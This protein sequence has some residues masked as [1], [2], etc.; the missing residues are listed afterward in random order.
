M[1]RWILLCLAI[2]MPLVAHAQ[3]DDGTRLERLI[4]NS[5]SDGDAFDVD[6]SGFRGALSSNATLERLTISDR[7]G[8]WL[9]LEDA[10]LVWSRAA[11]LRGRLEVDELS[12]MRLQVMRPPVAQER[13][14]DLPTAEATPFSLPDLPVSIDID[15]IAIA[16]VDLSEPVIGTAARLSV[17]GGARLSDGDGAATLDMRRLDGPQG[18]IDLDARFSNATRDLEI[19]LLVEE[20]SGGLIGEMIDLPGRPSLRL[21]M[22]GV[23]PL[24]D[25]TADISLSTDGEDRLTGQIVSARSSETT[26]QTIGIDLN[27][28]IS[29][30]IQPD[31]RAFFGTQVA[32][33]SDVT[34][35]ADGR[36]TLENLALV[37][38]AL[39]IEGN[40][41]L[42]ENKQPS[43]FALNA[44]MTDPDGGRVRLPIPGSDVTLDQMTLTAGFD[45]AA[46]DSYDAQFDLRGL[47]AADAAVE[48]MAINVAGALTADADGRISA[49][50]ADITAQTDNL[51]HTDPALQQALGAAQTLEAAIGWSDGQ[52]VRLDELRILAGDLALAGDGDL[53][54]GDGR[55]DIGFVLT[56]QADNLSRFEG[57]AGQPLSG[58]LQTSLSGRADLLSGAFE[59]TLDGAAQDLRL[60]ASVPPALFRGTTDLTVAAARDG[61]GVRLDQLNLENSNLTLSGNGALNSTEG[62]LRADVRLADLGLF[63][64][65]VRGHAR[66]GL[67]MQRRDGGPWALE[68]DI[69]GPQGISVAATGDVG[70]PDGAV[71]LS[72]T[73]RLPLALANPALS[74]RSVTG[75]LGFDLS[76]EGQPGLDTL[77]GTFS[78]SGAR[79]SLPTLQTALDNLSVN[80]QLS[81]GRLRSTVSGRLATGGAL[82]ADATVDLN[83]PS[84]PITAT[85]TGRTLRLIDPTLYDARIDRADLRYSGALLGS[86]VLSGSV[87]LGTVEIRVPETGLGASDIPEIRHIGETRAQRQTRVDA[88]LIARGNGGDSRPIG[89]DLTIDAPGQ[90]FI[91]GRGL[92]AEL[93]GSLRLGGTSANV[94]PAGRFDLLRGRLSILGTRLDLTE[95]SATLQGSLDPFL[96]LLATSRAGAYTIGISI[97]GPVTNPD[98]GFSSDPVLPEDEVLAQ[99]LFGRSIS[100][101]SAIQ[102][103]QLADAAASLAGG[104]QNAGLFVALRD[105]LGLD[106]LDLETDEQGN[107]ALRAGRYLSENIYTDLS[108][109]AEGETDLSLNIDLTSDI[110]AR[111]SF[112]SDGDSSL[113][114]FFERDY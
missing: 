82:E 84:L 63:N 21:S 11:L 2:L 52:P 99:L 36:V 37:S 66:A 44:R 112:S 78:T 16:E 18:Q 103:L 106:D 43:R 51:Q 38:A 64:D 102:L 17:E 67:Q 100:S 85:V 113:G 49:V 47:N 79:V 12:A 41:H 110:T 25:F 61:N 53:S 54:V 73:G 91:R 83:Q 76:I 39:S 23:G 50:T 5:I 86:A 72:V 107:A 30:L 81:A 95:G 70:L 22:D 31:Y 88:G 68:T 24:S 3:E 74:P 96:R 48:Q 26:D 92:D 55:L 27:G 19:A 114:V 42:D 6:L 94:L 8:V 69:S 9:V 90:I 87:G 60:D 77:G 71:E 101:L 28:D 14:L 15:R 111:G 97:V 13:G 93:G 104:S 20:A 59:I 58:Q 65:F 89:L 46:G 4:E 80:G 10:Q 109:N 1:L 29:R 45:A 98:I 34:L 56:A 108:I 40:L 7:D 32:L 33:Q 62:D 57:L 75:T 35:F 105:G